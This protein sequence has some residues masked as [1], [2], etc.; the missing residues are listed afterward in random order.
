MKSGSAI[1]REQPN[2]IKEMEI[3]ESVLLSVLV[4]GNEKYPMT[5]LSSI[6]SKY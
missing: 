4:R 2:E 6:Y 5:G 3:S 1:T